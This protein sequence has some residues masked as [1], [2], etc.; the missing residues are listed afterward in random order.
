MAAFFLSLCFHSILRISLICWNPRKLNCTLC[1]I[2]KGTAAS[3]SSHC[4]CHCKC[5]IMNNRYG[6]LKCF[7]LLEGSVLSGEKQA[8][9][10]SFLSPCHCKPHQNSRLDHLSMITGFFFLSKLVFGCAAPHLIFSFLTS[11]LELYWV[12]WDY[13]NKMP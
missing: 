13:H 5:V 9:C 2:W 3:K 12:S 7:F 1:Q 4:P 6:F 11:S 10:V 8:T